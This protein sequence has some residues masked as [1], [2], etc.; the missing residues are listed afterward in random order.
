MTFKKNYQNVYTVGD[1]AY[2]RNQDAK[3]QSP[4]KGLYLITA[5]KQQISHRKKDRK[6]ES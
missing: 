4:R 2:K 5:V 6:S 1:V 3:V